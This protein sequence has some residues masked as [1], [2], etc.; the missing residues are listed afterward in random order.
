MGPEWKD[1]IILGVDFLNCYK[2][3]LKF[4]K[5]GTIRLGWGEEQDNTTNKCGLKQPSL[6]QVFECRGSV[7]S[8]L[9]EG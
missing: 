2:G 8:S 9:S 1:G 6:L 5:D 7:G 3:C 4:H